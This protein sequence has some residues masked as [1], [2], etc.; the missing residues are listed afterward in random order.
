LAISPGEDV[1][2]SFDTRGQVGL[3]EIASGRTLTNL[4]L[5][6]LR[7][8]D[9]GVLAFSRDGHCLAVCGD[10]GVD[11]VLD[12][13]SG[14]SITLD[15]KT[16]EGGMAL[17]FS[18]DDQLLA[19]GFGYTSQA[20]GLFDPKSGELRGQLITTNQVQYARSL[21]FSPDGKC[22]TYHARARSMACSRP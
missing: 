15:T 12:W 3:T 14:K 18:P 5:G 10:I 4:L 19:A 11:V 7:R 6:P 9:S 22:L 2:A 1:I 8:A 17:A 21:A 16:R 13:N 20:I